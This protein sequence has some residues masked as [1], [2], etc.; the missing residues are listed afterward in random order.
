MRRTHPQFL[1]WGIATQ[2]P[3]PHAWSP[4]CH[5]S[6]PKGA[7]VTSAPLQCFPTSGNRGTKT[8]ASCPKT[9]KQLRSFPSSSAFHHQATFSFSLQ[10]SQ[11]LAWYEPIPA[12]AAQQRKDEAYFSSATAYK[13][14]LMP[15]KFLL[16]THQLAIIACSMLF[17]AFRARYR[18]KGD[19][20]VSNEFCIESG[21]P[22]NSILPQAG[23]RASHVPTLT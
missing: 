10:T 18:I 13:S 20:S 1:E 8:K 14:W 16:K 11:E 17:T 2:P 23:C 3:K 21:S 4:P 5:L 7:M 9:W 12:I 19:L 15:F 22:L 6:L